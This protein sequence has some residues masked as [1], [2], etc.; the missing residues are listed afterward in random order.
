LILRK[1]DEI[2][3]TLRDVV[4]R[5]EAIDAR[6]KHQDEANERWAADLSDIYRR[7]LLSGRSD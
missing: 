6:Q 2:A 7:G 3:A 1:L 4:A 5:L